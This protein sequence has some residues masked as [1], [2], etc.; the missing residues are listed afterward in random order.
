M[1]ESI[2]I[3]WTDRHWH[4]NWVIRCTIN[5]TH[6]DIPGL[7]LCSSIH[8]PDKQPSNV[9]PAI[10]TEGDLWS[11]RERAEP[12]GHSEPICVVARL[13]IVL[14]GEEKVLESDS[15]LSPRIYD[16]FRPFLCF[17]VKKIQGHR[18]RRHRRWLQIRKSMATAIDSYFSIHEIFFLSLERFYRFLWWVERRKKD[19]DQVRKSAQ[20][21]GR[22]KVKVRAFVYNL[23]PF[24]L[25]NIQIKFAE[26]E[27]K[28]VSEGGA[29]LDEES[30]NS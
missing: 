18:R 20:I 3:H 25:R 21:D 13:G 24:Y 11:L 9:T 12:R 2:L 7:L 10:K 26:V 8:E 1:G 4:W 22:W 15:E 5:Y 19:T 23:F 14:Q 28:P 6:D 27:V 17:F 30:S 29:K 16:L